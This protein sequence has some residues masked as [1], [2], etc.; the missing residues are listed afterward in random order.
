MSCHLSE[1]HP[2]IEGAPSETARSLAPLRWLRQSRRDLAG[3]AVFN[4]FLGVQKIRKLGYGL[5][6]VELAL[7]FAE[8]KEVTAPDCQKENVFL[9]SQLVRKKK[10]LKLRQ[11]RICAHVQNPPYFTTFA[12]ATNFRPKAKSQSRTLFIFC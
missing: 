5:V 8:G 9:G 2:S 4:I 10:L 7:S 3:M 1:R 11:D 12:F 6:A